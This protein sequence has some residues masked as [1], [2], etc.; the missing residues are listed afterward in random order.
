MVRSAC[1]DIMHALPGMSY[2]DLKDMNW[3]EL[4]AW[5]SSAVRTYKRVNGANDE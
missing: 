5:R 4:S 2:S 3:R 1:A